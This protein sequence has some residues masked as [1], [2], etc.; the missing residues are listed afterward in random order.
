VDKS[1]KKL[2]DKLSRE[3]GYGP[4][5]DGIGHNIYLTP[6][7]QQIVGDYPTGRDCTPC[8]GGG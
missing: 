7:G 2:T 8:M 3:S 5:G 1:Y 6:D 4:G